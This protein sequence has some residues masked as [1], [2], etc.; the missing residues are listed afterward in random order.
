MKKQRQD[1]DCRDGE[2]TDGRMG[3]RN[4]TLDGHSGTDRDGDGDGDGKEKT[5]RQRELGSC[6][7]K[8]IIGEME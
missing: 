5:E 7:T 8:E 4:R 3:R 6:R 1:K 2:L